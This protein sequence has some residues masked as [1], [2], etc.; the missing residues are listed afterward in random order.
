MNALNRETTMAKRF[1]AA[2]RAPPS[3]GRPGSDKR[4]ATKSVLCFF[5]VTQ[6][7]RGEF[8]FLVFGWR[9]ASAPGKLGSNDGSFS[10]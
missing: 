8:A 1:P 9:S 2:F 7:L 3:A 10:R 6:C 4:C 5:S